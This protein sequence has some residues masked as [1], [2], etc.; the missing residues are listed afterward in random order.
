MFEKCLLEGWDN[1]APESIQILSLVY[2]AAVQKGPGSPLFVTIISRDEKFASALSHSL[3]TAHELAGAEPA[4]LLFVA[5]KPVINCGTVPECGFRRTKDFIPRVA[6]GNPCDFVIAGRAASHSL[7]CRVAP[8]PPP[9]SAGLIEAQLVRAQAVNSSAKLS[10]GVEKLV[11]AITLQEP[12]R[13]DVRI[14]LRP[15]GEATDRA[16]SSGLRLGSVWR[17]TADVDSRVRGWLGERWGKMSRY[18]YAEVFLPL[19]TELA[20]ALPE[21]QCDATWVVSY[22]R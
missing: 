10:S 22:S 12:L 20:A 5:H 1:G 13:V 14:E 6:A 8:T 11:D 21:P 16:I 4:S 3:A 2:R 9:V 17:T 18:P 15:L 7:R 19:A